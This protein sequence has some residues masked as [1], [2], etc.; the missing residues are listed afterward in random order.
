MFED[1]AIDD[2]AFNDLGIEKETPNTEDGEG[3]EN[4]DE[5]DT[6]LNEDGEKEVVDHIKQ[7]PE[8]NK[9]FKEMRKKLEAA[10]AEA[11]KFRELNS[12]ATELFKDH[13]VKDINEY[14]D[15]LEQQQAEE[16]RNQLE[17]KGFDET[18]IQ[19]ILEAD[20]EKLALKRENEILKEQQLAITYTNEF[21]KLSKEY[22]DLVKSP[23]DISDEVWAKFDKGYDMLDAFESVNRELIRSKTTE[24]TKQKTLNNI[25]SKKHLRT[26]SDGAGD[27][28]AT[29]V[30]E[31]VL[32]IYKDMGMDKK[33]AIAFHKKLYG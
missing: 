15:R 6:E 26:E 2:N 20:K 22:P 13:D 4:L 3:A 23:E 11:K 30:P 27:S 17:E 1:N 25:S 5:K 33:E 32:Q 8:Q 24:A 31:D 18:E 19:E 10:E 9:A 16:R 29:V 7:T 28:T 14:F 21:K 12:R